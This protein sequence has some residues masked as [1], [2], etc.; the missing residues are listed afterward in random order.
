[1]GKVFGAGCIFLLVGGYF[2]YTWID[3]AYYERRSFTGTDQ[4]TIEEGEEVTNIA[5]R[6]ETEG[7]INDDTV[8][9]WGAWKNGT[10]SE[11]RSGTYDIARNLSS[12][13]IVQILTKKEP[14]VKE[15]KVTFPEGWTVK[16]MAQRLNEKGL[17][18]DAFHEQVLKPSEEIKRVYDFLEDLPEGA[19]L[20]GYMF[21]DTYLFSESTQAE[22][23]V[24]KM[25]DA[26]DTKVVQVFGEDIASQ[27]KSLH[28]III[29][30]SIVEMEVRTQDDRDLVSGIFWSRLAD[31]FPLQSDATL[32]YVLQ[33]NA[34]QH[35]SED[36]QLESPYNS[37][38]YGGL[39]PGPVSQPSVISIHAAV[40]PQDSD[41]YYFLSDPKTG[42]THFASNFE[43]HKRNK[44][45]VGL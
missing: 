16:K 10:Y 40:H 29:M 32:E 26:F 3:N 34:V 19:T 31:D 17:P 36:L 27:G 15:I 1:V 43:D 14:V 4:F 33:T 28:E 7:F 22:F 21:P 38:K 13:E 18:G 24:Q 41:Y 12:F 11:I 42:E 20:E 5:S 44:I 25:L 39:P 23:I 37:Y 35:T 45:K 9:L 2:F 6:L 8:F 30:A